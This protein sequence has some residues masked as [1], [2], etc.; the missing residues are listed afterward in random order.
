MMFSLFLGKS[1]LPINLPLYFQPVRGSSA[2][3]FYFIL[4]YNHLV[5]D[6]EGVL[7]FAGKLVN[8]LQRP[9]NVHNLS[10]CFADPIAG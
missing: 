7:S 5:S 1:L 10:F 4:L 3:E 2:T 6:Q 9:T 8:Q